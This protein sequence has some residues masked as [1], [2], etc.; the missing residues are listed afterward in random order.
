MHQRPIIFNKGKKLV[1]I[2][3]RDGPW[4]KIIYDRIDPN[5]PNGDILTKP[6]VRSDKGKPRGPR[7][8]NQTD[9]QGSP[10]ESPTSPTNNQ[11]PA[12]QNYQ[13]APNNQINFEQ[14]GRTEQ[15]REEYIPQFYPSFSADY[16]ENTCW[17]DGD[18]SKAA[19]DAHQ[20]FEQGEWSNDLD[21]IFNFYDFGDDKDPFDQ[22]N[23]D[24]FPPF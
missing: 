24:S 6:A 10:T 4:I 3:Y 17:Y 11:L 14:S 20:Y 16:P 19:T 1:T 5:Q 23:E 21:S 8:C 7:K 9:Q 13:Q 12:E 22:N 15:P 2:R 18:C